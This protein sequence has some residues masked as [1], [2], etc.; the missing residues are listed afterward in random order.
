MDIIGTSE[1]LICCTT[2][3]VIF[4]VLFYNGFHSLQAQSSDM[5]F[6]DI[7]LEAWYY[8]STSTNNI[9]N[10]TVQSINFWAERMS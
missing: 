2:I 10:D 1:I 6:L 7:K 4:R 5:L 9:Y 8:W 3:V